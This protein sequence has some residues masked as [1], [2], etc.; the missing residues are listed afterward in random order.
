[1]I[2][3]GNDIVTVGGD[4]LKVIPKAVK[5]AEYPLQQI[6]IPAN[7]GYVDIFT[8]EQI[9]ESNYAVL[10]V[11]CTEINGALIMALYVNASI[12]TI[13]IATGSSQQLNFTNADTLRNLV[14]YD[15]TVSGKVITLSNWHIINRIIFDFNARKVHFYDTNNVIVAD[16]DMKVVGRGLYRLL[17]IKLVDPDSS[18]QTI[19]KV[20]GTIWQCFTMD[21]A[22]SV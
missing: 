16:A 5:I 15:G 3:F 10:K 4:W 13:D 2:K 20:A 19:C 1:M 18:N 14:A 11:D 17:G 21:Q 12:V 7:N 8:N 6:T 22:L 9:T